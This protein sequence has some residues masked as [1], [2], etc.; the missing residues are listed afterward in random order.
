MNKIDKIPVFT[1]LVFC[2]KKANNK[3]MNK[4]ILKIFLI[5]RSD[6]KESKGYLVDIF[7]QGF[8]QISETSMIGSQV[9][10][11]VLSQ[12]YSRCKGTE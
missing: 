11:H 9:K 10:E 7:Q 2:M 12:V 4:L 6:M 8:H 5:I 1:D 3:Q